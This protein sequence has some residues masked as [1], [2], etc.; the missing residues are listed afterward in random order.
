M[1][2]LIPSPSINA[3]TSSARILEVQAI[4]FYDTAGSVRHVVS[5]KMHDAA[6]IAPKQAAGQYGGRVLLAGIE[7]D[8]AELHPLSADQTS[9]ARSA[10]AQT[11]RP[12]PSR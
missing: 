10:E 7:D 1:S 6:A 5:E 2:S 9:R 11:R 8:Q 3:A 12:S 4:P